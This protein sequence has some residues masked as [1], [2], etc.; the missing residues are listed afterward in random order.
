[1]TV[2]VRPT[3]T[4][5]SSD[6]F[7]RNV[8]K[9]QKN[10]SVVLLAYLAFRVC[11]FVRVCLSVRLSV[12][13]V[14]TRRGHC[15]K[16]INK[17][18]LSSYRIESTA[19]HRTDFRELQL[20]ILIISL[21]GRNH[22]DRFLFLLSLIVCIRSSTSAVDSMLPLPEVTA[23]RD[24]A[25]TEEQRVFDDGAAVAA[26]GSAGQSIDWRGSAKNVGETGTRQRLLPKRT[27]ITEVSGYACC[28]GDIYCVRGRCASVSSL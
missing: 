26:I 14:N 22:V 2:A 19:L 5:N 10:A 6:G 9:I 28:R 20:S 12:C 27:P 16:C 3:D 7:G 15:A 23:H 24:P 1:M 17:Q 4:R 13:S 18:G 8:C 11:L 21:E 25:S